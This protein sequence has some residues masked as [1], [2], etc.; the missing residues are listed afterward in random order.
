MGNADTYDGRGF[1]TSRFTP[2]DGAETTTYQN[3]DAYGKAQKTQRQNLTNQSIA[4]LGY[5]YD[6]AG[7]T[8][9]VRDPN[10]T[11]KLWK[12]FTY[13]E[14]NGTNDWRAGKLWKTR[15]YNDMSQVWSAVGVATISETYTYGGKDGRLSRSD[16]EFADQVGRY[17]RFFQTYVYDELGKVTEVGYPNNEGGNI[18]LGRTRKITNSYSRNYLTSVSGTYNNQAE[19]WASAIVYHPF[20]LNKQVVHGNGVTD[21]IAADPNG[22]ARLASVSTTGAVNQFGQQDNLNTGT[23]QFDGEENL[24]RAGTEYFVMEDS[25]SA[26]PPSSTAPTICSNGYLDPFGLTYARY[27]LQCNTVKAFYYYTAQDQLFRV[28]DGVSEKKIWFFRDQSGR[29]LTTY[30]M[31]HGHMLP[32]ANTWEST[33]DYVYRGN[34]TLATDEKFRDQAPRTEHYHV[35]HGASGMRT[36]LSRK[37]L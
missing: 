27:D 16:I 4:L 18:N 12:E 30:T 26:P 1:L 8:T 22:M 7:R 33:R 20:G 23:F 31:V 6:R 32:W 3:I 35:G 17:E 29:P 10:N 14:T 15:R 19:N 11:S 24:M 9:L 5:V 21:N 37:R 28:E 34:Y 13:A 36:D 25:L 2:D